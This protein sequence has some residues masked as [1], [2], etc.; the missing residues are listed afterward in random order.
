M[1]KLAFS[2]AC[3]AALVANV[4]Y[5]DDTESF[6]GFYGGMNFGYVNQVT[7][8]KTVDTFGGVYGTFV[9]AQTGFTTQAFSVGPVL[10]YGQA[11]Y[12]HIY[13]GEEFFY[14]AF[15]NNSDMTNSTTLNNY[16]YSTKTSDQYGLALLP[17]YIITSNWL[18][19]GRVSF[20]VQDETVNTVQLTSSDNGNTVYTAPYKVDLTPYAVGVGLGTSYQIMPH[21]RARLEYHHDFVENEKI[22]PPG[23]FIPPGSPIIDLSSEI[24]AQSD[25]VTF[26]LIYQ[27]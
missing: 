12:K 19:Y 24:A 9:P 26:G 4:S 11:V 27:F 16:P 18:V 1:K 25:S 14:N 17:G 10:G 22:Y 2:I 5:A 23:P 7:T 3:V 15:V 6:N 20:A 8:Q 21:L 13:L